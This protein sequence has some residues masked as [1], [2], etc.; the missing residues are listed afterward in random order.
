MTIVAKKKTFFIKLKF[1]TSKKGLRHDH[2]FKLYNTHDIGVHKIT[3]YFSNRGP[4]W[5]Y[6]ITIRY[7]CLTVKL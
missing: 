5:G 4:G 7:D 6:I 2:D 3:K 1:A